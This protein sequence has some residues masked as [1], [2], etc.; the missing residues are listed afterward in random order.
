ML[1][2]EDFFF[3]F[4]DSVRKKIFQFT[5]FKIRHRFRRSWEYFSIPWGL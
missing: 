3:N 5:I 1:V 2:A 4:E